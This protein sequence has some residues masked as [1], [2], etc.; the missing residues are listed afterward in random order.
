MAYIYGC[1]DAIACST[2]RDRSERKLVLEGT[3]RDGQLH[4]CFTYFQCLEPNEEVIFNSAKQ[5]QHR[6]L[7]QYSY[8][9]KRAQHIR[10]DDTNRC[11][12]LVGRLRARRNME[13][14]AKGILDGEV[15]PQTLCSRPR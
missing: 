4:V 9:A 12:L 3:R 15:I 1:V 14:L 5:L 11:L 6:I 2:V 8:S 10:D 13:N 7:K